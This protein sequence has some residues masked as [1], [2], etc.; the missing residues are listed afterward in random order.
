MSEQRII[1]RATKRRPS[2]ARLVSM[3]GM[4]AVRT[5]K[6]PRQIALEIRD[7]RLEK[8]IKALSK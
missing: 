2:E 5:S 6:D 7:A 1:E 8:R 4:A 3:P